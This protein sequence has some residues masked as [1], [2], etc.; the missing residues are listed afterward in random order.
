MDSLLC[1]ESKGFDVLIKMLVSVVAKQWQTGK[2]QAAGF[3]SQIRVGPA[4]LL[5][6]LAGMVL[7]GAVEVEVE[8]WWEK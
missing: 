5:C 1:K 8:G 4:G 2:R 6:S 3:L 7:A